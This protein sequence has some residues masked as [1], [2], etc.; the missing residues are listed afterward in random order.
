MIVSI[1][2]VNDTCFRHKVL[3]KIHGLPSYESL[4]NVSTEMKADAS[5]VPSTLGGGQNGHLGLL[6]SDARHITVQHALP[7]AT[8]GDPGPFAPPANGTGPQIEA[9]CEAWRGLNREFETCQAT[10]K[11]LIAQLVESIDSICLRSMLNRTAGQHS[12]SIRAIL[13]QLFQTYG[14]VTPQQVKAKD[15]EL[16][17][18]HHDVSQPVDAIFN[19]IDDLSDLA[20]HAMSPSPMTD[21]QMVD[22][23]YVTFAKQPLLQPD[24]QLWNKRPAVERAYA[25]F[26]QHLRDAHSDLSAL[27]T[28]SDVCHQQPPHHANLATIADPVLQRILEEQGPPS[29]V[30]QAPSI[31]PP[32]IDDHTEVAN[33]LQR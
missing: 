23:A 17:N 31:E 6:L 16:H 10:D 3:T 32:P 33:S 11:A 12:G 21:Q 2:S 25:N 22:L 14:K 28:A 8:P 13:Q 30:E 18:M 15:M 1:P 5:S 7:W 24:L 27:P 29:P 4:Q 19:C 9:A 20:D 26:V